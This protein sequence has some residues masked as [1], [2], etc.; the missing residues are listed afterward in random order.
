MT[1]DIHPA[2][3]NTCFD[4]YNPEP[5]DGDDGSGFQPECWCDSDPCECPGSPGET[6]EDVPDA[7]LDIESLRPLFDELDGETKAAFAAMQANDMDA[8]AQHAGRGAQIHEELARRFGW[9]AAI[10]RGEQ[11]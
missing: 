4:G 3:P 1:Y 10:A 6:P 9:R 8:W 11:P 7:G 5:H 2:G